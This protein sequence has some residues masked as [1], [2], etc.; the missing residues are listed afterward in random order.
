MSLQKEK[1]GLEARISDLGMENSELSI[2]IE[3]L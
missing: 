3:N 1:T 2:S